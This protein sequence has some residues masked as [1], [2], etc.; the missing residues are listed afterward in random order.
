MKLTWL[1][2]P[3]FGRYGDLYNENNVAISG[4]HTHAGPGGYLQYVVYIVTSLGFVRKSFDIIVGGIEQS[5]VEPH[6]GMFSG[7][8]ACRLQP[9][10]TSRPKNITDRVYNMLSTWPS[11]STE[12]TGDSVN[13]MNSS[14]AGT[15]VFQATINDVNSTTGKRLSIRTD[16]CGNS[17]SLFLSTDLA[18]SGF[19]SPPR[20]QISYVSSFA[21]QTSA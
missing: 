19:R 17:P 5:I 3:R 1:C 13:R 11:V 20:P 6:K 8:D 16:Y 7:S 14:S 4:I 9:T 2:K 21:L 10:S 18:V 15:G 12:K